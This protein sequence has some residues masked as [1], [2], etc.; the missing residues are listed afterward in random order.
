MDNRI[1][2]T[3]PITQEKIDLFLDDLRAVCKKHGLDLIGSCVDE[4]IWSEINIDWNENV[5]EDRS[6]DSIVFLN[7]WSV[8]MIKGE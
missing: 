6:E 8:E 1:N 4:G 7:E 5:P 2:N 3:Q